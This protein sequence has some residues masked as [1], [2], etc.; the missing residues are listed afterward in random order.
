[1]KVLRS[2]LILVLVAGLVLASVGTVLAQPS[3]DAATAS[4]P[5]LAAIA[6]WRA[7]FGNVTEVNGANITIATKYSGDVVIT[8]TEM[9]RCK[10][11]GDIGWVR[12]DK[13]KEV[14]GG[15]LSTLVGKRVAVVAINVR[16]SSSGWL[17]GD[18][19][20]FVVMEPL[21]LPLHQTT[22]AVTEF[23][24]DQNGNGNI[25]VLDIHSTSHQF[26]IMS[27][28]TRYSPAGTGPGNI[29]AG[30]SFV[31][32]VYRGGPNAAPPPLARAIVLWPK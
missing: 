26:T 23:Y 10:I 12:L 6:L 31:T 14:L 1:M 22:G 2:V 7:F 28:E 18:A 8:L 15:D 30:Q 17:T 21:W 16:E 11:L 3:T 24:T 9:T 29:T 25:T 19:V 4:H 5:D 20:L 27:N 13:F 32:V